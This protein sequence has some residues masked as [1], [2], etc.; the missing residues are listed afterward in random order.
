VLD[1]RVPGDLRGQRR[2]VRQQLW[3]NFRQGTKY[4][5]TNN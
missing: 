3:L 4:P 1:V 2:D 5:Y